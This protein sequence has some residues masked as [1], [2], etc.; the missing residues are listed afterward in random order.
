MLWE[1]QT[2]KWGDP[3][4]SLFPRKA[5]FSSP[6]ALGLPIQFAY[7]APRDSFPVPGAAER[8][9]HHFYVFSYKLVSKWAPEARWGGAHPWNPICLL[10]RKFWSSW[11]CSR[12]QDIDS[13]W[14]AGRAIV[15]RNHQSISHFKEM[16]QINCFLGRCLS[17]LLSQV[18]SFCIK[19]TLKQLVLTGF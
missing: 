3:S 2:Q 18:L 10:L 8:E 5:A 17:D 7:G 16:K 4:H 1:F 15:N 9:E 19:F 11:W 14:R 12:L 6:Q 13:R